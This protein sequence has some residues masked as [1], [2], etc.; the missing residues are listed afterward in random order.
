MTVSKIV[1]T[2]TVMLYSKV[3]ALHWQQATGDSINRQRA[4]NR[5]DDIMPLRV[6]AS[7]P[8]YHYMSA[9][10]KENA[11]AAGGRKTKSIRFVDWFEAAGRDAT[12]E[13]P[14]GVLS[15]ELAGDIGETV[16]IAENIE[17]G[18]EIQARMSRITV[19]RDVSTKQNFIYLL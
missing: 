14:A 1:L 18:N 16:E 3:L 10:K 12:C 17:E 13:I 9:H 6:P 15:E 19:C 2:V 8:S 7:H 4:L 5:F 11:D